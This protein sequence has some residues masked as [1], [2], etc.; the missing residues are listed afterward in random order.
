MYSLAAVAFAKCSPDES[1]EMSA[2]N[3]N[4]IES[5]RRL[6]ALILPTAKQ[7]SAYSSDS[8]N[9]LMHRSRSCSNVSTIT[10]KTAKMNLPS[11]FGY[12]RKRTTTTTKNID[13]SSSK[14]SHGGSQSHRCPV[15]RSTRAAASISSSVTHLVDHADD[16]DYLARPH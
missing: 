14:V 16:H 12:Q 6:Q 3:C 10:D 5:Y 9:S 13:R 11:A 4:T 1:V 8:K 7:V 15:S 2:S